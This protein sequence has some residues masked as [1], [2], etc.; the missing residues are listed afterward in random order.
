MALHCLRLNTFCNSIILRFFREQ[1][2]KRTLII[3]TTSLLHEH[4]LMSTAPTNTVKLCTLAHSNENFGLFAKQKFMMEI[5]KSQF[6][7]TL[8]GLDGWLSSP[9]PGLPLPSHLCSWRLSHRSI[10]IKG[11]VQPDFATSYFCHYSNQ[12]G[13]L[14]S[15][16]WV[17]IFLNLVRFSL[18]YSNFS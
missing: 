18:S 4:L 10:P 11:T 3:K 8:G 16:Q 1:N 5:L 14:T 17:E 2:S 13:P 9:Y 15:D 6:V 7:K 12:P